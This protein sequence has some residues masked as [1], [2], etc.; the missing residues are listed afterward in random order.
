[1]SLSQI[2]QPELSTVTELLIAQSSIEHAIIHLDGYLHWPKGQQSFEL[3]NTSDERRI[4]YTAN[5]VVKHQQSYEYS[6]TL[7]LNDGQSDFVEKQLSFEPLGEQHVRLR[8]TTLADGMSLVGQIHQTFGG[9][10]DSISDVILVTKAEP[11][12]DEGPRVLFV[13][14]AFES[15][16]GYTAQEIIGRTP[17]I[18]QGPETK[19]SAK[20]QMRSAF[21]E[22]KQAYCQLDNYTKSGEHFVVELHITPLKD[23]IGWWTHW[24]SLQRDVTQ[25]IANEQKLLKQEA[26]LLKKSRLANVGEISS[27]VFHEIYNPLTILIG[28]LHML[29]DSLEERDISREELASAFSKMLIAGGRMEDILGGIRKLSRNAV[30]EGKTKF[31]VKQELD[32]VVSLVEQLYQRDQVEFDYKTST[33]RPEVFGNSGKFQQLVL[34]LLSNA[35]DATETAD[36]KAVSVE[37]CTMD[38]KVKIYVRNSGQPVDEA[39]REKIFQPFFTTKSN[40]EGTGLGLSIV[41]QFVTEMHGQVEYHALKS[42]SEFMIQLPVTN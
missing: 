37:L 36:K 23:P 1:M 20:Q 2:H 26:L 25:R 14:D 5:W 33:I 22:W 13:N 19:E 41:K 10:V 3:Q 29:N 4:L 38:D 35:R 28:H 12:L 17:R 21:R 11:F 24:I 16:T 30:E 27:S 39:L 32:Q 15:M 6:E 31:S 8:V 40:E 18:L 42:G 34:N 9:F 7:F